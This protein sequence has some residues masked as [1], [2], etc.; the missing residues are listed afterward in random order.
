MSASSPPTLTPPR[1]EKDA[2]LLDWLEHHPRFQHLREVWPQP[3]QPR[4]RRWLQRVLDS[5]Q[6]RPEDFRGTA[7]VTTATQ[8][9]SEILARIVTT[10]NWIDGLG[11][12]SLFLFA[13]GASTPLGWLTASG[14][15]A[16][17]LKFDQEV[18]TVVARGRNGGRR[19]AHTAAVLGLVPLSLIKSLGTGIGVEVFQ[20]RPQ[21]QQHQASVLVDQRLA[22]AQAL[23]RLQ[24][25]AD[26]TYATVRQ[27]CEQGQAALQR[28]SHGDPRWQSLQVQL[29]GEWSERRQDWSRSSRKG[30]LPVC[31]QQKLLEEQ[32]RSRSAEERT[33]LAALEQERLQLGNNQVFLKRHFPANHALTFSP[34]GE[35]LSPVELVSVAI[36][37]F[38]GRLFSPEW[39]QLGLPLFILSFSLLTSATACALVL[40]HPH[41]PGVAMSWSEEVRRERDR[42][43]AAQL[44]RRGND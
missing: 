34:N 19:I 20:N 40:M 44:N 26:P 31:I 23:V 28:L 5:L 16:L 27:Q 30:Q 25:Q 37:S 36:R 14:M 2:S 39:L 15:T 11:N 22:E 32:Q 6:A 42:W 8:R 10:S 7:H 33:R 24:Q 13:A 41:R 4:W 38:M 3:K 18:F 9:D 17:L 43:L 21:L 1:E 29:H 12:F 35:F